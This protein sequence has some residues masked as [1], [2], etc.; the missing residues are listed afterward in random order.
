MSVSSNFNTTEGSVFIPNGAPYYFITDRLRLHF[1]ADDLRPVNWISSVIRS[2]VTYYFP[3]KYKS[4]SK[5]PTAPFTEA[6]IVVRLAEMYLIRAEARVLLNDPDGAKDDLNMIRNRAGLT[7]TTATTEAELLL[8]IENERWSELFAEYG[9]RW[10]DLKR[11]DRGIEVIGNGI[12][13]EDLL[14]PVPAAE[15][16]K[17]PNLGDQNN[18]Y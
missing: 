14:Y 15:F 9:H 6:S 10:L 13:V 18:G 17:N 11:T 4:Y 12:I 8:A 16:Q 3:H 2:S 1:E 5:L 7:N